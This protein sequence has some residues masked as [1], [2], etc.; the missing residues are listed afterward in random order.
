[1]KVSNN[2]EKP[3]FKFVSFFVLELSQFYGTEAVEAYLKKCGWK[4]TFP[5]DLPPQGDIKRMITLKMTP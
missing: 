2:E 1:M 5:K 4:V 3:E